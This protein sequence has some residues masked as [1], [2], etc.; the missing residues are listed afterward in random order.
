VTDFTGFNTPGDISIAKQFGD[1]IYGMVASARF[2]GKDEPF[3]YDVPSNQFITV[4]GVTNA[5][6]PT[7]QSSSGAWEAPTIDMVGVLVIITHPGYPGGGGNYFGWFDTTNINA[8]AWN[9]GNTTGNALPR[10]PTNVL[11]FNNRAFFTL[12]N[13]IVGTD[14]LTLNITNTS[15]FLT[16]SSPDDPITCIAGIPLGTSTQGI[17]QGIQIFKAREIHQLT[18]DYTTSDLVINQISDFAGTSAKRSVANTPRGMRFLDVD[19]VRT[20]AQGIISEPDPD[21]RVPF[22]NA[23]TP[24]RVS[25]AYNA[26]IY[27]I[28]VQ[29]GAAPGSPYEEYWQDITR[30]AWTGPHPWRQDLVIPYDKTFM[31]FRSDS[32]RGKMYQSDPVQS[33]FSSFTELGT[34]ME[35]LYATA[36]IGETQA[37]WANSVIQSTL[38]LAF[39]TSGQTYLLTAQDVNG[40]VISQASLT[41]PSIGSIWNAFNWGAGLWGAVRYGLGPVQIPWT[42]PLVFTTVVI[43][44]GGPSSR[45]LKV[46]AF[47][48]Q[49]KVLNYIP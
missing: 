15:Q 28:C 44:A 27:R 39:N 8:P 16:V 23:L 14:A 37:I 30:N 35:W 45:E 42:K 38:M 3:V 47:K 25:S 18:G 10:V 26:G 19:G 40:G 5:A 2:A 32:Y 1:R 33:V 9:A 24:S 12:E 31:T 34:T 48:M 20:V 21:V 29:N 41:S 36:P 13:T 6:C 7:T 43:Q 4:S 11:Q 22:I 49:Y 46:G 17:L